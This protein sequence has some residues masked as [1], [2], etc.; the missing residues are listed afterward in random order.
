MITYFWWLI[1]FR[2]WPFSQ[3]V[4]RESSWHIL[5]RSSS[6]ECGSI[7]GYHRPSSLIGTP[8]SSTNFGQ[9]SGTSS[10]MINIGY[11]TS[12]RWDTRSGYI[13]RKNTL[14]GPII[15]SI[16]FAMGLTPSPRLWVTVILSSTLPP[17]LACTQCSIVLQPYFPPLL[18]TSEITKQLTPT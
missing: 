11:H 15:I 14:Q 2:R 16:H 13:F 7:L 12:L 5:P 8:G 18:D 10:V 4:R 9:V 1:S 6:N 17:S 3:P